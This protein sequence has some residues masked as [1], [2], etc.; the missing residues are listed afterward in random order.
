MEI[1]VAGLQ[2]DSIVDGPGLRFTVFCQGCSHKCKGCH[3]EK[4]HDKNGGEVKTTD[5]IIARVKKN[6]LLSGVTLSGG[7]PMEQAEAC[8]QIAKEVQALGLNVW[9]YTGYTYEFLKK[10]QDAHRM[11]LLRY[12]D[13]LVD[14]PFIL[15]QR[16]LDL[17]FCGS[18]N[19]RLIDVKETEKQGKIVLYKEE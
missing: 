9:V 18:K 5:E 10:E 11:Q 8:A 7:E 19:Q 6:P 16:S 4:T 12:T 3:N 2:N 15:A 17:L 1:R 13:V 14:G